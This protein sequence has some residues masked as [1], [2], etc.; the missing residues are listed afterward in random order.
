MAALMKEFIL[1]KTSS[2][3]DFSKTIS[4]TDRVNSST[5]TMN[6]KEFINTEQECRAY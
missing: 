5:K 4:F 6:F 1:V 3:L 2:I